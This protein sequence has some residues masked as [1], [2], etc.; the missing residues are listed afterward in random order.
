MYFLIQLLLTLF[1][2][3]AVLDQALLVPHPLLPLVGA[4]NVRVEGSLVEFGQHLHMALLIDLFLLYSFVLSAHIVKSFPWVRV[5]FLI[6]LV[7]LNQDG[8]VPRLIEQARFTV[9]PLL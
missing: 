2:R 6:R 7:V 5:Y 4:Q 9:R 1:S 3:L 8:F